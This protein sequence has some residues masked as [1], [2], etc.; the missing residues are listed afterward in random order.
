M[1]CLVVTSLLAIAFPVGGHAQLP[2][3]MPADHYYQVGI[4]IDAFDS[5]ATVVSVTNT[6]AATAS[7]QGLCI[8]AYVTDPDNGSVRGCCSCPIGN[9]A[10]RAFSVRAIVVGA[11][12][13]PPFAV[14]LISSRIL[15]GGQGICNAGT[16]ASDNLSRGMAASLYTQLPIPNA[17]APAALSRPLISSMLSDIP[18]DKLTTGCAPLLKNRN[19]EFCNSSCK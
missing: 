4:V 1:R 19:S 5:R 16:V 2:P 15:S 17:K 12:P 6:D 14:E 11:M 13:R 10:S 9:N 3:P 7:G 18:K 8:N